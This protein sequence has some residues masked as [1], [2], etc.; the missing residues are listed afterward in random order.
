MTIATCAAQTRGSYGD[1]R[2]AIKIA[3]LR[4]PSSSFSKPFF[5]SIVNSAHAWLCGS[6]D[7]WSRRLAKLAHLKGLIDPA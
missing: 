2:S 7:A 6:N 5:G 4:T 3:V 1:R